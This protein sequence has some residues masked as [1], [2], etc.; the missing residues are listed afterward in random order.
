M[1]RLT[2]GTPVGKWH[3]NR[4][5]LLLG[6]RFQGVLPNENAFRYLF[7]VNSLRRMS[8][9]GGPCRYQDA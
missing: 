7:G 4:L 9:Q 6:M 1:S 3:Q 5:C 8:I 2:G